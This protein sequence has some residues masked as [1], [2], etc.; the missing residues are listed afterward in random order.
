LGRGIDAATLFV[1][2]VC[3]DE[4]LPALD[5]DPKAEPPEEQPFLSHRTAPHYLKVIHIYF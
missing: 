1:S 5:E 4:W 3:A 2:Q